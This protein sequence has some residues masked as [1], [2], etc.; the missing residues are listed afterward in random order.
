M[1]S[2]YRDLSLLIIRDDMQLPCWV[3]LSQVLGEYRV[4]LQGAEIQA[5]ASGYDYEEALDGLRETLESQGVFL[6]CNRFR[7]NAM[8]TSMC[9]QMSDGLACYL[10]KPFKAVGPEYVVESL[11]SAPAQD[12]CSIAE[13]ES[14]LRKFKG[15]FALPWP[16]RHQVRLWRTVT[17][18]RSIQLRD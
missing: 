15:W 13:S 4:L 7:R 8:V 2:V 16:L 18:W 14:Y 17:P 11:G 5:T 6:L 1:V 9:R 12:V 3:E 10:V